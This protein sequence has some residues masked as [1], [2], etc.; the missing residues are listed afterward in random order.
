M[1]LQEREPQEVEVASRA[2]LSHPLIAEAAQVSAYANGR[3]I[4][5]RITGP[6]GEGVST[7]LGLSFP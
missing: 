3:R 2:G 5:F 6:L 1:I 7:L 4:R